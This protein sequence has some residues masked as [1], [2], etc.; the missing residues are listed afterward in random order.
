MDSAAGQKSSILD[1]KSQRFG[2]ASATY[3]SRRLQY[4]ISRTQKGIILR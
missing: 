1:Q 3:S 4:E 2:R